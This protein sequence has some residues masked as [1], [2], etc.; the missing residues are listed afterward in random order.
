MSIQRYFS[1]DY[2]TS[3]AKFIAACRAIGVEPQRWI[4]P[5]SSIDDIELSTEV[6]LIGDPAARKLLVLVSGVHGV[7]ALCGSACQTGLLAEPGAL[8]LPPDTALLL[9]H[10][11]NCWGAANLRRNNEDNV[12][13][14]RNFME[15][16]KPLPSRASYEE[17]HAALN[18]PELTG[19]LRQ[20]SDDFLAAF[21]RERGMATYIEAIM[22]GQYQHPDGFSFGGQSAVWSNRTI[23]A[24]L[25]QHAAHARHVCVVEYHTGLGPYA[26]G[27][28]VTM[29]DGADLERAR[30]WYGD[31]ILAPNHKEPGAPEEFY[32]VHGHSTE[33]YLRILPDAAVTSVVLEYGTYPPTRTLPAMMADH[34][35]THHGDAASTL[36]R[37][38]RQRLLD[39]HYPKDPDWRQAIWDR[40]QQVIAQ[41]LRGL[42][43]S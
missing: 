26:Y 30:A 5:A 43:R 23:T 40:S 36:G 8:S 35:L 20:A 27:T 22:G 17:I 4:N 32:R 12:D 25:A 16:G 6:A 42:T 31:W 13:L 37:Q 10:A 34:W 2:V 39:L 29:H 14:C 33:G 18:C 21:R 41:S 24:I 1:E 38:I 15:F 7:E 9:V 11:I 19:P 28:A 3:R